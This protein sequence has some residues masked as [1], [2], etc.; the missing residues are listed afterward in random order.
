M[1]RL[2]GHWGMTASSLYSIQ[3]HCHRLACWAAGRAAQRGLKEFTV[4]TGKVLLESAGLDSNF[5]SPDQLPFPRDIDGAHDAWRSSIIR[6]GRQQGIALSHGRAA[7][8]IN[9]YLKIRFVC[10]GHHLHES[11]S[12]LHPPIDSE[13]LKALRHANAGGYRREWHAAWK[14]SWTNFNSNEYV[15]V[16]KLIRQVAGTNPLWT[17]EE[18]WAG[19]RWQQR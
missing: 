4:Q 3:E 5:C 17:I 6:N 7:K 8:L 1:V 15:Q 12:A 14:R 19:Y 10:G 18:H 11:V 9:V 16:I 2:M 13:L